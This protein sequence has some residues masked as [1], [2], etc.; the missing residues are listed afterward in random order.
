MLAA[1]IA[2]D[3]LP[4]PVATNIIYYN[5]L[6]NSIQKRLATILLWLPAR[7][8]TQKKTSDD[9]PLATRPNRTE[10]LSKTTHKVKLANNRYQCIKCD[11]SFSAQDTSLNH[12]LSTRCPILDV[13]PVAKGHITHIHKPIKIN[14]TIHIGNRSSH[15]SHDLYKY[16]GLIYCNRCGAHGAKQF[17]L[18]ANP[19][20]AARTS[21]Q[22]TLTCIEQDKIPIGYKKWPIDEIAQ[23]FDTSDNHGVSPGST[24]SMGS[25]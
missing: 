14:D 23:S 19:C 18:L 1:R 16:K 11:N 17:V 2:S 7:S 10:L 13:P 20:E 3:S 8:C 9:V 22:R 12:W 24:C 6:V 4:V 15:F 5:K 21:G 25:S